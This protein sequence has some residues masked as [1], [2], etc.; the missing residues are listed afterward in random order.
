MTNDLHIVGRIVTPVQDFDINGNSETK[1]ISF[2]VVNERKKGDLIE[3]VF[4]RVNV[5]NKAQCKYMRRIGIVKGDTVW[6]KG[7]LM[8]RGQHEN[9]DIIEVRGLHVDKITTKEMTNGE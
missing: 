3:R 1:Y 6:V 4:F 9:K 8:S 7:E 2:R 5:Y